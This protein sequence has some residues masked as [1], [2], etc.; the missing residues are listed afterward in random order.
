MPERFS[1]AGVLMSINTILYE[2]QLENY[3]CTLCYAY[4][5]L[6]RRT[7]TL[8][9]SG[10]PYVLK[11][12]EA[13]CSAIELPG[14][15]LG[16][17]PGISYDQLAVELNT[18]DIYVFY[19]DGITETFNAD[20]EEFGTGRL[21]EIVHARRAQPAAAIVQAVVDAVE[22]FRGDLPQGDDMTVVVVKITG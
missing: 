9:N 14:L 10:L 6:K 12:T 2:R 22:G 11:C 1:P 4:F 21:E 8:A 5:D 17:F 20:D 13:A 16:S 15:P 7:L 18:G 3:Y 19:T